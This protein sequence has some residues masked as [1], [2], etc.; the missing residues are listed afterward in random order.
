L[1]EPISRTAVR[2]AMNPLIVYLEYA[3]L[4]AAFTEP[5]FISVAQ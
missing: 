2:T 5:H 1:L 4:L 3:T